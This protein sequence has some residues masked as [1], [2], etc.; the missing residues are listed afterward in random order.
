MA[1]NDSLERG[2]R[3]SYDKRII[4][5]VREY[6]QL[7]SDDPRRSQIEQEVLRIRLI[8]KSMMTQ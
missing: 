2:T 1:R 4:Q 3:E 6:A 8:S 5:L 7:E